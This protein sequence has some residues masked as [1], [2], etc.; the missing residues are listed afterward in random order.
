MEYYN[1]LSLSYFHVGQL[2]SGLEANTSFEK[3]LEAAEHIDDPEFDDWKLYI[4]GNVAF[5]NRNKEL[6]QE[7]WEGMEE[8]AN[9]D[10]VKKMIKD[11]EIN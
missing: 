7:I 8:G 3:A 5:L 6:L 11:L 2:Q 1:L 9:K 4:K 10:M